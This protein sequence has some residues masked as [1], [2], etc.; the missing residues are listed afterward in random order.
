MAEAGELLRLHHPGAVRHLG[1]VQQV[2]AEEQP[3]LAPG[4][5]SG[6]MA[7]TL[8][9]LPHAFH[10]QPVL[11]VHQL[12]F[13]RRDAEEAGVEQ[14]VPRDEAAI[15]HVG[16]RPLARVAMHGA[17]VPAVGR[18]LL[19]AILAAAQMLSET[20]EVRAFREHA[21]HRDDGDGRGGIRHRRL[22]DRGGNDWCGRLRHRAV[23]RHPAGHLCCW[24]RLWHRWLR[25]WRRLRFRCW[26]GC[27][28]GRHHRRGLR[29]V[30]R[31]DGLAV[32]LRQDAREV[33]EVLRLEEGGRRNR[34]TEAPRDL[35]HHLGD[36]DGI[37]AV[38]GQV[39]G[40]VQLVFGNA[41]RRRRDGQ[42]IAG[43]PVEAAARRRR[44]RRR[45]M[46]GGRDAGA[47]H[48]LL[49]QLFTDVWT[50]GH[51]A[52]ASRVAPSP[53]SMSR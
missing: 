2:D 18:H 45:L 44:F 35:H 17:P 8:D 16:E 5:R 22:R 27:W 34:N 53:A 21:L 52:S 25:F 50:V 14:I 9:Q 51:D 10:E 38:I 20:G 3:H 28:R 7:G 49:F 36:G 29:R 37:D 12:G 19:D 15:F 43:Q 40:R 24:L 42:H 48:Q 41:Q 26:R 31:G 46:R 47:A 11:R 33:V 13:F 6:G 32:A 1:I 23:P 39:L 4:Q 30:M